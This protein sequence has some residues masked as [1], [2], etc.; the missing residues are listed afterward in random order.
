MHRIL[1]G[2]VGRPNRLIIWRRNESA[3]RGSS[4][5]R[6]PH[7]LHSNEVSLAITAVR[8]LHLQRQGRV[9]DKPAGDRAIMAASVIARPC[10]S[11]AAEHLGMRRLSAVAPAAPG[12]LSGVILLS[13]GCDARANPAFGPGI[14]VGLCIKRE[15]RS[16]TK[17]GTAAND[18][19]SCEPLRRTRKTIGA[20]DVGCGLFAPQKMQSGN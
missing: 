2:T 10:R 18:C 9:T 13:G 4:P 14:E 12:L 11:T 19:Q 15:T 16:L 20:L 7:T 8:L 6:A 17:G 3:S 1:I 5:R